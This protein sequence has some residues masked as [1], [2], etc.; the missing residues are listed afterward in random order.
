MLENLDNLKP[1]PK[2]QAT[3]TFRP[4]IEFDGSEGTATTP[5]YATE[6]ESFDEFLISAGMNPDE[7]TVI[8][9]IRTSRWQQREDGAWLTSYR[10]SFRRNAASVDLP[11]LFAEARRAKPSRPKQVKREEKALLVCPSDFQVGKTGS[12]GGTAEL[13]ARV[14]QSFDRIEELAKAGK[15]ERIYVLELGDIIESFSSKAQFNQLESNDLSPMQQV[16]AASALMFQLVKR[17]HK[18]APIT[19]GSIASNHCQNRFAGQQVGKPG[20]DDWGIVIA[21]QL[22]RLT[23]ELGWDVNYL[24][25]QPDDEGFAFEYGVNIVGCVHGHQVAKPEAIPKF[26]ADGCF[27]SQWLA[28]VSLLLTAHFHHTK[29]TELGQHPNGFSKFWVQN[30]T[31][32]AGSDWYRRTRGIDSSTGIGVIEL[33]KHKPFNGT[34]LKV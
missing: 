29:I 22:A 30:P 21:Q 4:G 7:I 8:P 3:P 20:L 15:Y 10:F 31:S 6:P 9:P 5:G 23:S 26:W 12:R 32:D 27:G 19:Y 24:I 33:D 11:A 28:P 17:L 2:I 18:Y 13:I 16:D 25:P 1:A 34:V 14:M